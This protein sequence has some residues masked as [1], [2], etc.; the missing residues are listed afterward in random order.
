ME[1]V[2]RGLVL[3]LFHS[4]SRGGGD[5]VWC[6]CDTIRFGEEMKK[7]AP[8]LVSFYLFLFSL[9]LPLNSECLLLML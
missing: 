3:L 6:F 2:N 1:E 9:R 7:V 5:K 8:L 4:S